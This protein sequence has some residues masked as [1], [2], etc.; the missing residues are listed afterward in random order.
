MSTLPD[1]GPFF[2]GHWSHKLSINCRL[3]LHH[4]LV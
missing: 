1:L 2:R 3:L 4:Y